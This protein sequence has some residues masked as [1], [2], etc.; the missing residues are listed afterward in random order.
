MPIGV[1]GQMLEI[2]AMLLK[3]CK[4]YVT[5][6]LFAMENQSFLSINTLECFNGYVCK[7]EKI[8]MVVF[9]KQLSF[10]DSYKYSSPDPTSS[11][12]ENN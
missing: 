3:A 9:H 1:L 12:T 6:V 10:G 5:S 2:K 8:Q 7:V 11:L 4:L